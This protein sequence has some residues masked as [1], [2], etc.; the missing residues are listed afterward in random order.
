MILSALF[1][2]PLSEAHL[3][4]A[5][6][7]GAIIAGILVGTGQ[8]EIQ[9]PKWLLALGYVCIGWQIGLRFTRSVLGHAAR[10]LPQILVSILAVIIFCGGLAYILTKLLD[11]DPLT[12]YLATSPGA[13]MPLPSL[14][15]QPMSTSVLS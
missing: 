5:L 2:V 15:P 8:A 10:A 4:A 6:L 7:L 1:S 3:P 13:W 12:A 11:I 9:V 14:P